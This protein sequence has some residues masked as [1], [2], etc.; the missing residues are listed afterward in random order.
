MKDQAVLRMRN[1]PAFICDWSVRFA[2]SVVWITFAPGYLIDKTKEFSL[3]TLRPKVFSENPLNQNMELNSL[4]YKWKCSKT[5]E[6]IFYDYIRSC[7]CKSFNGRKFWNNFATLLL[8]DNRSNV[9]IRV[10]D[11]SICVKPPNPLTR[12][13]TKEI[14]YRNEFHPAE[15]TS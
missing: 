2:R 12:W 5:V 11:Q 14:C 13:L 15:T 6:V 4:Q 7:I 9:N 10:H 1:T 3:S 8:F